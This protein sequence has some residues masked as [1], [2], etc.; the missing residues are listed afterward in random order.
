MTEQ[1]A[2]APRATKPRAVANDH[3]QEAEVLWVACDLPAA[4]GIV[5]GEPELIAR[6]FGELL[7]LVG[8]D[9]G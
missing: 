8:N 7:C 1:P 3:K 6:V 4:M 5:Q 2:W 9:N